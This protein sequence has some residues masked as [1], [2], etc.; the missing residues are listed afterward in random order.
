[1]QLCFS[2]QFIRGEC[3]P[4]YSARGPSPS[5]GTGTGCCSRIT[6]RCGS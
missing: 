2:T 6:V 4:H 1:M 5:T 3:C